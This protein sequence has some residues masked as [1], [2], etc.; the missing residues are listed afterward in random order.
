MHCGDPIPDSVPI[1][2]P[3][4]NTQVYIL[5]DQLRPAAP[6]VTGELYAGGDGLAR[7]YLN[8]PEATAASF[9]KNRLSDDANDRIYRTGDLARWRDDGVIEFLGRVDTQVKILGYRIEP[10]EVE[11]VLGK[12]HGVSQVCVVAQNGGNASKRLVAFFVPAEYSPASA[13]QLRD[14][15]AAKLPQYMTPAQFVS[16]ASLP[17]S[18]NGKVD[19]AAL[20]Q[21]H[22]STNGGSNLMEAPET[23]LERTLTELWSR[24][25]RVPSVGL[26]DNFFDLGGDSL[27]LVAVHSHL[28]K[29]LRIEIPV[30]NLFEFTTIRKLARHIDEKAAAPSLSAAQQQ[31]QRQNQAFAR[32]RE[33]RSGGSS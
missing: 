12:H 33:N 19:R 17:L 5:D 22:P 9:L 2:R 14:F 24:V 20:I 26:D 13:Q 8:N 3:I 10:S 25:L 21:M 15:A 32:F 1:G 29:T 16:L 11:A 18:P 4:S 27:Q 23:H 7:G 28:Q 6:G 30:T 31:A